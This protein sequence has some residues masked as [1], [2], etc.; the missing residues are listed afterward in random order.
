M[1]WDGGRK[2]GVILM[3]DIMEF[4]GDCSFDAYGAGIRP[5]GYG[6]Q[7]SPVALVEDFIIPSRVFG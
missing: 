6:L 5:K 7:C 2:D 3:T 1:V 4:T